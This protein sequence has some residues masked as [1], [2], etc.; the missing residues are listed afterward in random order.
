MVSDQAFLSASTTFGL[1]I[2]IDWF[3]PYKHTASSVGAIY[4]TIMNLPRSMRYKRQNIIL[5]GLIP[6]PSEPAHD[7]N[8]FLGPL[9]KELVRFW[10][11]I[12]MQVRRGS[13]VE[14]EVVRCAL[15]GCACDL[16]AGRKVCGFLGHSASLGCSKCLKRFSG[17]VGN[18]N[19]S[20]FNR[21][22]WP[23]RTNE[24][25]R[26]SVQSILQCKTKTEQS[27]KEAELGCRYSELMKLPYFDP[28]RMLT[29]D[30]MH[31]LFLGTGK[32]MLHLWLEHGLLSSSQ[33]QQ[34]QDCV[35]SITV[36][37]DVGRIPRKIETG[38][39]GF[40]ADQF[41]NWIIIFSIPAL[42]GI[43]TGHHLECW[44]HF[45]LACRILCKHSLSLDDVTL[46][47][48][49]LMQFCNRVQQ[50][51]GESAV[52]PNMH[53]HAHLKDVILDYGP[54][55]G[56]WLFSFERYN[57]ILGKQCNNNRL[58]EPQLF[59]RFLCDNSAYSFTFPEDFAGDFSS[60]CDTDTKAVGS[61]SDTMSGGSEVAYTLPNRC[62]YST[63]DTQDIE[64]LTVLHTKLQSIPNSVP[65]KIYKKYTFI[66]RNGKNIGHPNLHS[67]P[68]IVFC[69]WDTDL[70]GTTPTTTLIEPDHPDSK[71][72]PVKV[73]YF[74]KV[75]FTVGEQMEYLVVAF[76][77]W[78]SPHPNQHILGKPAQV[79]CY[80]IFEPS[81]V[82][83]YLPV[84]KIIS[85]CA[86][87]RMS[88]SDEPVLVVVPLVE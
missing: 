71:F 53:M 42:Y 14:D 61:V 32:H 78:Y 37:H 62:S 9:V 56:F 74:A 40:T 70:Y 34:I 24:I 7:I 49:L 77:S 10:D 41:K 66:S 28:V 39:A 33:F 88:V 30:Q 57:G 26:Q 55:Y 19:Y 15:L 76:V 64:L 48:A 51:Y 17:S 79:W 68:C 54:V 25:H 82:H 72:R 58:I 6:G 16:P 83:S 31:N 69:E 21:S 13:S 20:G 60:L 36:P 85:R 12:S 8:T 67:S 27:K 73:H 22:T 18:M 59:Q 11:G 3:Q 43:L 75:S 4:L 52:T 44:R 81:G 2:N 63:L 38:F 5:V 80:D 23:P 1:M 29:V 86:H 84:D 50:I 35:D 45:V 87:C 65:N 47:D 46:A